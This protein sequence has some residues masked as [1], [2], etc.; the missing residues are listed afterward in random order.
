[1]ETK[2]GLR[3]G[4]QNFENERRR[5]HPTYERGRLTIFGIP[6]TSE[7]INARRFIHNDYTCL[8][9]GDVGGNHAVAFIISPEISHQVETCVLIN[10]RMAGMILKIGISRILFM[11]VY[12]PQQGRN[13]E[14]IDRFYEQLQEEIDK[15]RQNE[16]IIVMGDL[17]GHVG[18]RTEGYEQVIGYH[19]IGH[20]N[21][22]GDRILNVCNGKGMKIMNTY[23]QHRESH[24]YTWYGWNG[25]KQ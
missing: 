18:Q 4:I 13:G 15:L 21:T 6:E 17:N 2:Y 19:G 3:I 20:R 1:M 7:E 25:T 5:S 22:E 14:E 23:F 16:K 9:G 11:T 10:N 8:S 24:K 12:A